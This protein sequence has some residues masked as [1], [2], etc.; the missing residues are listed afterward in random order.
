MMN[1]GCSKRQCL[2]QVLGGSQRNV[3]R[4]KEKVQKR[5][6]VGRQQ[7]SEVLSLTIVEASFFPEEPAVP[8][9]VRDS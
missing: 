9:A 5:I 3:G 8:P 7:V 4:L 6:G 1:D 2:I